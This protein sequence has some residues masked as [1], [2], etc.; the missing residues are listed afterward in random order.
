MGQNENTVLKQSYQVDLPFH[1]ALAQSKEPTNGLGATGQWKRKKQSQTPTAKR[2]LDK[3]PCAFCFQ[4]NFFPLGNVQ[5]RDSRHF[6]TRSVVTTK[7]AESSL[8]LCIC[9]IFSIS[10]KRHKEMGTGVRSCCTLEGIP[11]VSEGPRH[12]KMDLL[13]DIGLEKKLQ[14]CG[15]GVVR[16]KEQ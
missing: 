13:I 7:N 15:W 2:E 14:K 1:C 8:S 3:Y 16:G 12:S 5:V 4:F 6:L 10:Q 9:F 11:V